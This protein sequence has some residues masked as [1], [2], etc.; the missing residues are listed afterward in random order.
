MAIA[1]D[2]AATSAIATNLTTLS[3]TSG[4]GTD[5]HLV[6]GVSW[7]NRNGAGAD[8]TVTWNGISMTSIGAIHHS[9]TKAS[10]S[11]WELKNAN[12]AASTTANVVVTF[13]GTASG[14]PN[15]IGAIGHS[16]VDQTT[17][18]NGFVSA[19]SAGSPLSVTVTSAV[20]DLAF[21]GVAA[22]KASSVAINGGETSHWAQ[23]NGTEG[24]GGSSEAGAATVVMDWAITSGG[25]MNAVAGFNI[26]AGATGPTAALTGVSS[27]SSVGTVKPELAS[28]THV[29]RNSA[30][31]A[32]W[33]N[34]IN[35]VAYKAS[36]MSAATPTVLGNAAIAG[37]AGSVT[38][39]LT[40]D[41]S[42]VLVPDH[43]HA[44]APTGEQGISEALTP[45]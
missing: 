45:V 25:A 44:S 22:Y 4:S 15:I 17:S 42:V 40:E 7:D 43:Q 32:F 20:D 28:I 5:R 33:A 1:I 37:G 6:V 34:G 8:V 14:K 2:G 27:T 39:G 30:D 13:P 38:I 3:W 12:I 26:L 35:V 36:T 10:L 9:G 31:T 11:F 41:V 23:A 24:G 19:T 29:F 18:T 21:S 16:G